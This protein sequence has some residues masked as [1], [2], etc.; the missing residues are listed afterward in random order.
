MFR[1]KFLLLLSIMAGIS[2]LSIGIVVCFGKNKNLEIGKNKE[3]EEKEEVTIVTSFYPMYLAVLNLTDGIDGVEVINL[4]DNTIGCLHD[5]QL[6]TK[7][8]RTL[9]NADIFVMNG[10]NMEHFMENIIGNYPNIAVINAT[11]SIKSADLLQGN[12]H[13]HETESVITE[14]NDL[15]EKRK[16][17]KAEKTENS[18]EEIINGHVWMNPTLYC[19]EIENIADGL[20]KADRIRADEYRKNADKYKEKIEEII[21]ELEEISK[22]LAGQEIVIF[23]EAFAYLAQAMNIEVIHT[24]NLDEDTAL[25]AGEIA[26]IIEEAAYHNIE[27]FWT[28]EEF[29]D[30]IAENIAKETKTK[31]LVLKAL[32]TGTKELDSYFIGMKYNIEVLKNYIQE[33]KVNE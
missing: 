13:K 6:T 20:M 15:A 1:K 10:S 29:A 32:V 5:Y 22:E 23:H 26:E 11:E 18:K 30:S 14:Q 31:V 16:E 17:N 19:E 12:I 7:D 24:V 3:E 2:I 9:A 25:S 28:E 27:I 21:V 8:M 33:I 4:T